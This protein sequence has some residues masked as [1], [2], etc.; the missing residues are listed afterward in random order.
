MALPTLIFAT[1]MPTALPTLPHLRLPGDVSLG[2]VQMT[3]LT[4]SPLTVNSSL[5]VPSLIV[6]LTYTKGSWW[7][8][9]IWGDT[10]ASLSLL[11]TSADPKPPQVSKCPLQ[12]LHPGCPLSAAPD[13]LVCVSGGSGPWP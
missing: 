3:F 9:T 7:I 4:G 6:G 2:P 12:H 8:V 10:Q 13:L 1:A 5:H 11:L